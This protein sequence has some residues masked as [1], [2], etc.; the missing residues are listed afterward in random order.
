MAGGVVAGL[1]IHP[2]D[3]GA[4]PHAHTRTHTQVHTPSSQKKSIGPEKNDRSYCF[5]RDLKVQSGGLQPVTVK[6]SSLVPTQADGTRMEEG[7][8]HRQLQL[9]WTQLLPE[10]QAVLAAGGC[11]PGRSTVTA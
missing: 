6:V 4:H 11:G 8:P 2:D 3:P 7:R 10:Q 5:L 1:V 9:L